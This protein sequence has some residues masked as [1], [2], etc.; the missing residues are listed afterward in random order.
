MLSNSGILDPLYIHTI[1]KLPNTVPCADINDVG[2]EEKDP[3]KDIHCI[4]M[5]YDYLRTGIAIS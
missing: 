3:S 2:T 4:I 5:Q 1:A